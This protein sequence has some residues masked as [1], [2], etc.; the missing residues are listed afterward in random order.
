MDD[1]LIIS[2]KLTYTQSTIKNGHY[3]GGTQVGDYAMFTGFSQSSI[4]GPALSG[5][6]LF[7]VQ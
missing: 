4:N 7:K 2:S 5:S 3:P 1:S 6:L